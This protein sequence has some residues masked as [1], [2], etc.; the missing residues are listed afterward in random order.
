MNKIVVVL[1]FLLPGFCIGQQKLFSKNAQISFFSKA[2]LENIEAHNSSAV[3]VWDLSSGRIAFSV[4]IKGFHFKK[5][6]MQKHFNENYLQ[7]DKYPK[8]VFEGT[9]ANPSAVSLTQNGTYN[10][11]INGSLNIHGVTKPVAVSAQIIVL[12]SLIQ[13]KASFTILLKDYDIEIPALVKNNISKQI[14]I[15]VQVPAYQKL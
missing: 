10:I 4:L 15:R 6:L 13:A 11:K 12:N 7:S 3:T 5:A 14:E 9:I 8:A 1:L 2:R